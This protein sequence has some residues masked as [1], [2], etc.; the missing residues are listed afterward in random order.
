MKTWKISP[1]SDNGPK[2]DGAAL[3]GS[4]TGASA[5]SDIR[6]SLTALLLCAAADAGARIVV[7][8]T[9]PCSKSSGLA[10]ETK[11][12]FRD[13]CPHDIFA[14]AAAQ[15][16]NASFFMHDLLP[17]YD[18]CAIALTRHDVLLS[19]AGRQPLWPAVAV[20]ARRAAKQLQRQGESRYYRKSV[21]IFVQRP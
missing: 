8:G 16:T 15:P 11:N 4:R 13:C 10:L 17:R 20:T 14:K 21:H 6:C 12:S 3:D 7:I 9:E 5:E 19:G 1:R 18:V 2:A